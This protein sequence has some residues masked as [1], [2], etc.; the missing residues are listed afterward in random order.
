MKKS[1]IIKVKN[2]YWFV[3]LMCVLFTALLFMRDVYGIGVNKYIFVF[4]TLIITVYA[5]LPK[6]ICFIAF[7][8]PLYVG[9]PGNYMTIIFLIKFLAC[10]KEIRFK[11]SSFVVTV[12]VIC[13]FL[14]QC[15]VTN[16][17]TFAHLA[18][19]PGVLLVFLMFWYKGKVNFDKI[20]YMYVCGVAVTGLIMLVSTLQTTELVDL[21]DATR[22]LGTKPDDMIEI[23]MKVSLDPNFYGLFAISAISSSFNL[24]YKKMAV[25]KKIFLIAAIASCLC[26]AL[27]GLSRAFL[28]VLAIWGVFMTISQRKGTYLIAFLVILLVG[29]LLVSWFLPDVVDGLIT[30]FNDADMA[31]GN[32]RTT[33]TAKFTHEWLET[34]WSA[35]FGV[36]MYNCNVHCMPLQYLFG[37]GFVFSILMLIFVFSLKSNKTHNKLIDY[38]PLFAAFIM[39]CTVPVATSLTFMFPLVI[40]LYNLYNNSKGCLNEPS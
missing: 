19:V 15:L 20:N 27:I 22:R 39:S 1:D 34:I 11:F 9:L 21:M 35:F 6:L 10:Y 38:V 23:V 17:T 13:Y 28:L 31:T 33:L 26:V 14:L 3:N 30:R 7:I 40:V 5:D 8:M 29:F 37:G 24:I 12:L 4:L 32:N 2:E 18:F 36:G 16:Y 25:F